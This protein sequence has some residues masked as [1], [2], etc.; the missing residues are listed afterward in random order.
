MAGSIGNP[1][2]GLIASDMET[3]PMED[4]HLVVPESESIELHPSTRRNPLAP[5]DLG[6]HQFENRRFNSLFVG[7]H[8]V[9]NIL[10]YSK[11]SDPVIL[12]YSF[13]DLRE[14]IN[15]WQFSLLGVIVGQKP[16]YN[17]MVQYVRKHWPVMPAISL[18]IKGV[19]VFRFDNQ[20]DVATILTM[21]FWTING[22]YPLLLKQWESCMKFDVTSLQKLPIW[23]ELPDLDLLFWTV[24]MLSCIASIV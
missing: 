6:R 19:F 12:E 14:G 7:N 2:D 15:Y 23:I 10:T 9:S 3:L 4:E 21:G 13:E 24:N 22:V 5:A 8:Q 17:A 18:T 16:I 20:Q 1:V 11:P